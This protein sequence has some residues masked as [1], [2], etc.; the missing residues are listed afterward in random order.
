MATCLPC[1]ARCALPAGSMYA[2]YQYLDNTKLIYFHSIFTFDFSIIHILLFINRNIPASKIFFDG[3]LLPTIYK[4]TLFP[5]TSNLITLLKFLLSITNPITKQHFVEMRMC[6]QKHICMF[7][8]FTHYLE[9]R[10]LRN[11]LYQK[12]GYQICLL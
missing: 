10:M 1:L 4:S 7:V 8:K 2:A 3:N 11:V 5:F 12:S 9:F 6:S